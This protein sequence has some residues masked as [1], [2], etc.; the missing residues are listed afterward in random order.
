MAAAPLL[1][2]AAMIYPTPL[3]LGA[4]GFIAGIVLEDVRT[5]ISRVGADQVRSEL[6]VMGRVK[7]IRPTLFPENKAQVKVIEVLG[8][9]RVKTDFDLTFTVPPGSG[10]AR[11]DEIMMRAVPGGIGRRSGPDRIA[12]GIAGGGGAPR[13]GS[14]PVLVRAREH[15]RNTLDDC[16]AGPARALLG[17]LSLGERWRAGPRVR[18]VLRK[19]GTYHLMAISGIHIGAAVL[20]ILVLLRLGIC[21]TQRIRPRI[22]RA[23]FLAL[24]MAAIG[25]YTAFTGVS[26]SALRSVVYFVLAGAAVLTGRNS[27]STVNLSWCVVLIACL[28]AGRQPD[29]S[30]LLSAL[31]VTGILHAGRG[32]FRRGGRNWVA[33][34]V[35]MTMGATLFTLPVAVWLGG[36][37]PVISLPANVFAGV[38]MGLFLVPAAVFIDALALFPWIP[39][40]Q[41]V[42]LW[43]LA[44]DPV[45]RALAFMADLPLAFQSLSTAGCLGATL[46]GFAGILV[47]RRDGYRMGR[48][49]A[50]L[51][52]T[53]AFST[54]VT[55]LVE[56]GHR[57]EV[58]ITFP[59]VGQADAAIIRHGGRTVL[60][61]C[62]PAGPP[63]RDSPVARALQKIGTKR[64]D[65]LFLSHTHPDHAGALEAI[66][67]RWPVTVV[68][69]PAALD[70]EGDRLSLLNKERVRFLEEGDVVASSSMRFTVLGPGDDRRKE[71]DDNRNSLQLLLEVNG[72]K[73]FFTGD[74]GWD[75]VLRS[76][77]RIQ[78]LDLIK[79][80]HH[81]SKVGFPPDGLSASL[82][83]PAGEKVPLTV[84]PSASPGVRPLPAPEVVRWFA[85]RG[86]RLVYSGDNGINIR[87]RRG[88]SGG[89]I[90]TVVDNHDWF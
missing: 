24:S 76:L 20:P 49:L 19:T 15:M 60:V 81:G 56:R 72:F 86:F 75:Q 55:F 7:G 46:C 73:A 61:D 82:F 90:S 31:A 25:I 21:T 69:L 87:Y 34:A 52:F 2:T 23:L 89:N 71:K 36:G 54:S 14:R 3:S 41:L 22:A 37:I 80:P 50:V 79:L 28:G 78:G 12:G 59:R 8:T 6:T 33:A 29:L 83:R 26:T 17:V 10:I 77:D 43:L 38:T 74:S 68:Y 39:I 30:L 35:Q 11:G 88:R 53:L 45:F 62:G 1:F 13:K 47:W 40:R 42:S 51:V 64:I 66:M 65:A 58:A 48:G 70:Q 85:E 16:P 84:C 4:S 63:G 67:G 5:P 32:R 9:V 18:D 44:A 57:N 27:R